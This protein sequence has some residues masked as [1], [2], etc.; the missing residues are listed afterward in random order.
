M[1][2]EPLTSEP[3]DFLYSRAVTV[4]A[5]ETLP[6]TKKSPPVVVIPPDDASVVIPTDEKL[7]PTLTSLL[8]VITPTASILVTSS[9][10]SV[11]PILTF[12][13]KTTSLSKIPLTFKEPFKFTGPENVAIPETLKF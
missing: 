3:S 6:P 1:P 4:P 11:P 10:V 12:F 7:P 9:Y 8:A 2:I 13:A 5:T